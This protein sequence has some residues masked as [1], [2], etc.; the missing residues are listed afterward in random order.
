MAG[1]GKVEQNLD[2][3]ARSLSSGHEAMLIEALNHIGIEGLRESELFKLARIRRM[4]PMVILLATL[5]FENDFN[6]R[7]AA[8][9]LATYR[10]LSS[11]VIVPEIE[12]LGQRSP[13]CQIVRAILEDD[14]S[15]LKSLRKSRVDPEWL[16]AIE[17]AVD[18]N[19]TDLARDLVACFLDKKP[20][21]FEVI[22]V[23]QSLAARQKHLPVF[24]D[25]MAFVEMMKA[26]E[27]AY[28]PYSNPELLNKIIYHIAEAYELAGKYDEALAYCSR[29]KGT[30]VSSSA[31]FAAAR[32]STRAGKLDAACQWFDG[33][34]TGLLDRELS[35]A[36]DA[37]SVSSATPKAQKETT[38]PISHARDA[39]HDLCTIL[40]P[41]GVKPFL[42]S[43]T[44][45][46]YVRNGGFLSHDKDVDVGIFGWDD[47]FN[48]FDALRRSG[49]FKLKYESLQGHKAYTI[50]VI[51]TG[52]QMAIDIFLYH[53]V[54]DKVVTGVNFEWGFTGT[55]EFSPFNLTETEFCGTKI[56]VPDDI[57]TNMAE[58]FGADWR[59]PDPEYQSHLES[60]SVSEKGGI[61]HMLLTWDKLSSGLLDKKFAK[62]RR[63]VQFASAYEH[64]PLAPSRA[65]CE[66]ILAWCDVQEAKS[67]LSRKVLE[68]A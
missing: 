32:I 21:A 44:L 61:V 4:V 26:L 30:G 27:K 6:P 24:V 59:V 28:R 55:F 7:E 64:N 9:V 22:A 39:L 5:R 62:V 8:L 65:L 31:Y 67:K 40:E 45:L 14:K 49:K 57:D 18:F 2:V 38:F 33:F 17:L 58:N 48:I 60:P 52:N 12:E 42:V 1:L 16:F 25:I 56:W 36:G 11:K 29:L 47:Q 19:R 54:G 35:E 15:H 34:V 13:V 68:H 43:G 46:G 66:R 63:V 10:S 37:A 53:H 50:P 20:S 41:L 51:H 3:I 23:I